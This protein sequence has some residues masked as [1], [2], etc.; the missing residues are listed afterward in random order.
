MDADESPVRPS[1]SKAAYHVKKRLKV[2]V[3]VFVVGCL[4]PFCLVVF[5]FF[6]LV[7]CGLIPIRSSELV[8]IR[9]K[10]FRNLPLSAHKHI[11]KLH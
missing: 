5:L 4:K 11:L 7:V 2:V 1:P 8:R 3:V 10:L 9:Q 6:T